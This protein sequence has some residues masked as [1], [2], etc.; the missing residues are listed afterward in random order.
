MIKT[1]IKNRWASKLFP[2][3]LWFPR[4]DRLTQAIPGFILRYLVTITGIFCD[5]C[6][7]VGFG[8]K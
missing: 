7:S 4:T 3:N 6:G 5:V 8:W 2:H 1:K